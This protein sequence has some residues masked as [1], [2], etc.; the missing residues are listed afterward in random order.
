MRGLEKSKR[1]SWASDVNLCQVKLFLSEESP[2]LIGSGGQDHLQ[3]KSSCPLY[4]TGAGHDDNLPPGF[5]E[6][7]PANVLLNKLSEISVIQWRCPPKFAYDPNWQVVDGDESYELDR[8]NEREM[9]VLEAV[10]PRPSS[11]PPNPSLLSGVDSSDDSD[12]QQPP[13]IPIT[14]IEDD[15]AGADTSYDNVPPN[16]VPMSSQPQQHAP[17]I[18]HS[19]SNTSTGNPSF[20]FIPP[21]AAALGVEPRMITAAYNAL[22]AVM[23]NSGQMTA[24]DPDLLLTILKDPNLMEKLGSIH[25]TSTSNQN[26]PKPMSQ[27]NTL[28]DPPLVHIQRA[29]PV[30]SSL[31]ATPS[32]PFYP[33]TVRPGPIPNLRPHAPEVVSMPPPQLPPARGVPVAKD[34]N[35]Y[36]S[37]IQQH[38]GERPEPVPQFN[39]HLHQIRPVQ[40]PTNEVMS[41]DYRPRIMKPCMY[42]NSPRGCRNGVNCAF[43]HDMSTQQRVS[44]MPEVQSAKRM[45]MDGELTGT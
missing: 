33:P 27:G 31:A 1:V 41:R 19:Q 9:R 45:K 43:Q 38:G 21:A 20:N 10:Y 4:T 16:T 11:I 37:L 7:H 23:A 35:Y 32:R 26:L 24:I 29:E 14:P 28:P 17:Q 13:L 12:Q 39:N 40:G 30:P 15:D 5:E 22:N 8:E 42:F 25:G 34:I 2:S 3:A 44:G 6:S 18:L 36:K